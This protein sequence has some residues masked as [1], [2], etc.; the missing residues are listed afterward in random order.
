MLIIFLF[1]Q[2]CFAD[3]CKDLPIIFKNLGTITRYNEIREVDMMTVRQTI[4]SCSSRAEYANYSLQRLNELQ[5]TGFR[6]SFSRFEEERKLGLTTNNERLRTLA[7]KGGI[8]PTLPHESTLATP[9]VE[10]AS[11]DYRNRL[12]PIRDQGSMSWCFGF[13]AADLLSFKTG[14][15]VSPIDAAISGHEQW[16]R[17]IFRKTADLMMRTPGPGD[18]ETGGRC[19]IAL[20]GIMRAGGYCLDQNLPTHDVIYAERASDFRDQ[21]ER[22]QAVRAAEVVGA[23]PCS[24]DCEVT[25]TAMAASIAPRASR[26]ELAAAVEN[27]TDAV[28]NLRNQA[29]KKR[30]PFQARVRTAGT[31]FDKTMGYQQIATQLQ[32]GN[33]V[34][35]AY[36]DDVLNSRYAK[37]SVGHESTIVGQ[38]WNATTKR[39]EF[40]LRNSWGK[41]CSVYRNGFSCESD[42]HLWIPVYDLLSVS[43]EITYL[44]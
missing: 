27:P 17:N 39:C 28:I 23:G 44:E 18:M 25:S 30:T 14:K 35:I 11:F 26:A 13:C 8:D 32:R 24:G 1:L 19:S 12:P 22:L 29:C 41:D 7:I 21:I 42:G 16:G 10:C 34:G 5:R 3:D 40:L 6:T 43:E 9:R 37:G 38:R 15:N 20:E 33:I 36:D 4:A 2:F 31:R